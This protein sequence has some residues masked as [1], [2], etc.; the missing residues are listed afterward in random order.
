MNSNI[1]I[2]KGVVINGVRWATRNVGRRG[3]FADSSEEY[4]EYYTFEEAKAACP[5]GWRLPTE[6]ELQSLADADSIWTSENGVNGRLFGN[7]VFLPA[8]G[9]YSRGNGKV[10]NKPQRIAPSKYSEGL[11]VSKSGN[12]WGF[13]DKTGKFVIKPQFDD[14]RDFSEGLAAVGVNGKYRYIDKTGNFVISPQ[15]N[16]DRALP[17]HDGVAE[18]WVQ[19]DPRCGTYDGVCLFYI[20]KTGKVLGDEGWIDYAPEIYRLPNGVTVFGNKI[21]INATTGRTIT[22][23][24]GIKLLQTKKNRFDFFFGVANGTLENTYISGLECQ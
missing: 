20:D 22:Q 10:V 1:T 5:D 15:F 8:A 2:E 3:K 17:F 9:Y 7:S 23:V 13:T 16:D 19:N 21:L 14:A 6:D 11:A 24:E 18:V 12:K 4:G